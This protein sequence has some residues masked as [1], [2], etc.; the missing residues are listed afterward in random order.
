MCAE[1]EKAA[2][3][4]RKLFDERGTKVLEEAATSVLREKLE[5]VE[6]KEALSHFMSYWHDVVR[7]SL[8][9]LACEAVGGDP[10]ITVPIGKSLTLLSGATDVH[11]D[12]IDKTMTKGR[13]QTVIGRSGGDIALIAGD[14][15]IFKGF[16]ELFD[17]LLHLDLPV[18]K[19]LDIAH[20]IIGLYLELGDA[21]ALEL[22][23][24]ARTDVKPEEYLHVVRKKAADIEVSMRIGAML[25]G[26]SR[27]QINALGEYGKL[28]GLIVLLRND[29][30][31][32]LDVN[33]LNSRIKNEALPLPILYALKNKGKKESILAILKK[34]EVKRKEARRLFTLISKSGDL[35]KL[36]ELFNDLKAEAK[37]KINNK[38]YTKTL[39]IIL[40][41]SIPAK[42]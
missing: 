21:E 24:R 9:S 39:D 41:A 27:E 33:M 6:A 4:V 28:L 22:K 14:I 5:C 15:L 8:I 3:E 2:E 18:E 10:S 26:G 40:D 31:D 16:A 37:E 12:M 13:R 35:D 23:F 17:G 29:L 30:E 19:K 25:G 34:G 42:P 36:W 38:V 20:A 7:P 11:D 32:M 1:Y